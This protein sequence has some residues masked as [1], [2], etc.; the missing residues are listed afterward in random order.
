MKAYL[1]DTDQNGIETYAIENKFGTKLEIITYGARIFKLFVRNKDGEL[2]DVI[3]G[4]ETPGEYMGPNPYFSAVI[5]RFANRIGN[6]KFEHYGKV[7]ELCENKPHVSLHGGKEGFDRKFW[8]ATINKNNSITLRYTSPDGEE[9]YPGTLKVKV[10]YSL[11]DVIDGR[12][13]ISYE[14]KSDKQTPV[15][16]TNHAYFNLTGDFTKKITDTYVRIAA[17]YISD[18]DEFLIP[19]GVKYPIKNTVYDFSEFK[20]IGKDIHKDDKYLN[21]VGGYDFNYILDPHG[22]VYPVAAAYNITSGIKMEV[23]TTAPCMQFYTG[24]FLSGVQGRFKY[25]KQS[26]FCMETQ[27]LPNSVNIK[28]APSA[29]IGGNKKFASKTEYF[30]YVPEKL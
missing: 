16:L 5:G 17:K 29:Y 13:T 12:V 3:A 10:K 20:K 14:A 27:L 30:F 18:I 11:S 25:N 28:G 9:G 21:L 8:K 2:V 23:R 6:A 4:F 1:V 15:N 26:A 7:Y 19:T 24:N 22:F